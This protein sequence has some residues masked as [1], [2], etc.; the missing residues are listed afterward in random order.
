MSFGKDSRKTGKTGKEDVIREGLPNDKGYK[1]KWRNHYIDGHIHFVTGSV[2]GYIPLFEVEELT[3]EFI[4]VINRI[5]DDYQMKFVAY[6]I[7]PEHYHFLI[8]HPEGEKVKS[9]L[10][11]LLAKSSSVLLEKIKGYDKGRQFNWQYARNNLPK[12][13]KRNYILTTFRNR[14]NGNAEYSLW[15]EQCRVLPI[16]KD[17]KLMVK[18]DYIHNNPV[19]RKVVNTPDLY[20]WSS[21]HY[22]E[23]GKV[24]EIGIDGS[25]VSGFHPETR[26]FHLETS[27]KK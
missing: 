13:I 10:R 12:S 19:R 22:W 3:R 14:A 1:M 11:T 4:T 20:E 16:N 17:D 5:K 7:M 24:V 6:V 8:Y 2:G 21:Y 26:G 9:F 18:I 25:C 15:K 23:N 27:P